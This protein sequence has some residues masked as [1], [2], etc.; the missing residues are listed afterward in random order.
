[1]SGQKSD[2]YPPPA[3]IPDRH[4]AVLATRDQD[5]ALNTGDKRYRNTLQTT[6]YENRDNL[7]Y[8]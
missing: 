4:V 7:R 3:Q 8:P 6:D 5:V 2:G 1:M